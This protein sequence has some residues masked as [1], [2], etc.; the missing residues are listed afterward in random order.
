MSDKKNRIGP[1]SCEWSVGIENNRLLFCGD[2]L[3]S[4]KNSCYCVKHRTMAYEMP[5]VE[6]IEQEEKELELILREEGV[7]VEFFE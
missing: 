6:E 3:S 7:Y 1:T 4:H 2:T 5:S